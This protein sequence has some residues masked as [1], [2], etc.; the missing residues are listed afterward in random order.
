VRPRRIGRLG[1]SL[2]KVLCIR[3]CRRTGKQSHAQSGK[4]EAHVPDT[5]TLISFISF[6]P[7]FNLETVI[8]T[9]I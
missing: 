1:K 7:D 6:A 4:A 5:H 9:E 2:L 3:A 8:K